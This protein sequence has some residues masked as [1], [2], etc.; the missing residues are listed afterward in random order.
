LNNVWIYIALSILAYSKN[1]AFFTQNFADFAK[2][3]HFSPH[4]SAFFTISQYSIDT[5]LHY[6]KKAALRNLPSD[7]LPIRKFLAGL[8]APIVGAEWNER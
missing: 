5:I 3:P 2:T 1:F 7:C 4:F 6:A 8:F